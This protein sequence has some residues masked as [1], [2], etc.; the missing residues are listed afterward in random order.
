[1]RIKAKQ[2]P[3]LKPIPTPCKRCLRKLT[4]NRYCDECEPYARKGRIR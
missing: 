1:M 2:T 3:K 4:I